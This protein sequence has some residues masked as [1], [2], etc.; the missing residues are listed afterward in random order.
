MEAFFFVGFQDQVFPYLEVKYQAAFMAVFMDGSYPRLMRVK[1][2]AVFDMLSIDDDFTLLGFAQA[3]NGLDQF[4]L[5]VAIHARDCKYLAPSDMEGKVFDFL[6]PA[7]ILDGQ[8]IDFHNDFTGGRLVFFR[9]QHNFAADHHGSQILL[10]DILDPDSI[11]NLAPPDDGAVFRGSH[12]FFQFMG[13]DNDGLAALDQPV[14]G[15]D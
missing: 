7:V 10:G 1:R 6:N 2:K 12:D 8:I 15:H 11:D 4:R 14:H 3:G 5:P 13:D 9:G